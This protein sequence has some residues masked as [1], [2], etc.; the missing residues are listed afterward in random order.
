VLGFGGTLV[1]LRGNPDVRELI[2]VP[3][4]SGWFA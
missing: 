4:G 3:A 2:E 1:M